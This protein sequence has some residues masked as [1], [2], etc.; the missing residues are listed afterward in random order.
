[1]T[2]KAGVVRAQG[3]GGAA[4]DPLGLSAAGWR[5]P[6][7]RRRVFDADYDNIDHRDFGERREGDRHHF[8]FIVSPADAA[9]LAC[10]DDLLG[11]S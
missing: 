9:Q 7:W 6:G 1:V 5:D 11:A 3:E 8:R 2:V 10:D 4:A